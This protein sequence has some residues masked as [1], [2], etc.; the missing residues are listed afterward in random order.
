MYRWYR[1]FEVQHF[2][3]PANLRGLLST[4]T[5]GLYPHVIKWLMA[6]Y[7]VP[8]AI[9]VSRTAMC[10]GGG[11]AALTRL[12]ALGYY[13]GVLLYFWV[14][15][16]PVVGLIFGLYLYISGNWLHVHYD[17]SFSALQVPHHK[18]FLRMH[19]TPSGDL[20]M[21]FLG[22]DQVPHSWAEDPRWRAP[23][24]GG[25]PDLPAHKARLPSRWAPV[26]EQGGSGRRFLRTTTP[27]EAGLKV[28][29]YLLVG[30]AAKAM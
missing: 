7:D 28:V 30:R 20:E 8:E 27:P 19:V 18:G 22:L 4:W 12:Q 16:T 17:E 29:D 6:L 9:A 25:Y 21:F 24:G 13:G 1:A 14:L 10:A 26:E 23:G 5:L 2:P 15:A 3:D 11:A